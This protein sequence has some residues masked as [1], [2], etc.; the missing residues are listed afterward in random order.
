MYN[1]SWWNNDH[2]WLT[3]L[4]ILIITIALCIIADYAT[5][6][7][8]LYRLQ[9]GRELRCIAQ[10]VYTCDLQCGSEKIINATNFTKIGN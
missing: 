5:K 10:C 1:N 2:S 8:G 6:K 7:D 9:D 4:F 3:V